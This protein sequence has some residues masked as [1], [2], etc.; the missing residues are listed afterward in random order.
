[1]RIPK[2]TFLFQSWGFYFPPLIF[3]I[4]FQSCSVAIFQFVL[5]KKKRVRKQ[6][7]I[8]KNRKYMILERILIFKIIF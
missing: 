1:M 2:G 3:L 4:F 5:C 8:F 7:F 6:I